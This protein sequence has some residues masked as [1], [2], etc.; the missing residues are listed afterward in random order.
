M[1]MIATLALVAG[2]LLAGACNTVQGA[3]Q[4][5][6]SVVRVFTSHPDT[7]K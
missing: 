7:P 6:R 5:A 3:K 1:R 2:C 4:D